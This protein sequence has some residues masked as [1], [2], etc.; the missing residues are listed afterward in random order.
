[1]LLHLFSNLFSSI[2]FAATTSASVS[3]S[4]NLDSR[5]DVQAHMSFFFSKRPPTPPKTEV[6]LEEKCLILLKKTSQPR[7]KITFCMKK[8][9]K[10]PKRYR[11]EHPSPQKP[12]VLHE[13]LKSSYLWGLK[14]KISTPNLTKLLNPYNFVF[15]FLPI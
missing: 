15:T 11:K 12:E 6:L 2:D 1:V 7:K 4:F 3:S 10:V 8:M 14:K 5:E 9:T 13:K